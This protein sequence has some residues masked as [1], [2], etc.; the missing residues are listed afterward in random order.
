MVVDLRRELPV[1]L[2][3]VGRDGTGRRFV[4]MEGCGEK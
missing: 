3:F 4:P 2:R 1:P